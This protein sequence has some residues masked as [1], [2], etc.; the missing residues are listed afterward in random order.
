MSVPVLVSCSDLIFASKISVTVRALGG[1]IVSFGDEGGRT[2]ALAIVD[3]DDVR[4]DAVS[5]VRELRER[6][7]E[8]PILAFVRHDRSDRIQAAREAGATRVL[9]RGAFSERLPTLVKEAIGDIIVE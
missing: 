5:I 9:S 8:L 3:L 7:G 1:E 4:S 6:S 2:P